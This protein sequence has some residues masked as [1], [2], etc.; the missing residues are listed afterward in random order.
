MYEAE[1]LGEMGHE[2]IFYF[3]PFYNIE[4]GGGA[5]YP[6]HRV[7]IFPNIVLASWDFLS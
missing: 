6:N 4:E 7:F 3:N 2:K 5:P 1:T